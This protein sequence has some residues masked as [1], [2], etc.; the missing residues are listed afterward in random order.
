MEHN[1]RLHILDVGHGNSAV[2]VDD[3]GVVVIDAGPNNTLLEFL[4]QE[5]ISHVQLVLISHADADHIRGLLAL[6]ASE[7]VSIGG[8]YLNSDAQKSS[9][10]WED[11][12]Y[13]LNLIH[14]PT[15]GTFRAS[16]HVGMDNELRCG[17]V[18]IEVLAPSFYLAG[19]GPGATDREG[20]KLTSNTVS[21]VIRLSQNEERIALLPGDIDTVGLDYLLRDVPDPSAPIAV[22]P[23]HGGRPGRTGQPATFAQAFARAVH[24]SVMLFS[25]GRGGQHSQPSE[26]CC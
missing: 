24:P 22:F 9:D 4:L 18:K 1:R 3:G 21:A 10:L 25:I 20:N 2:L 26:R 8:I 14:H 15:G 17:R 23:H 7:F 5:N 12:L 6:I 19:L 16:L 13:T 11:L